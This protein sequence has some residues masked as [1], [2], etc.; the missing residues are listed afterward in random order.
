MYILGCSLKTNHTLTALELQNNE[1]GVRGAEAMSN[2]L[3][4]EDCALEVLHLQVIERRCVVLHLQVIE[5]RCVVLQVEG[6]FSGK[7]AIV[8]K[9]HA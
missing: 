3:R 6:E 2:V 5:R 4:D 8:P 7:A 9:E 1:L